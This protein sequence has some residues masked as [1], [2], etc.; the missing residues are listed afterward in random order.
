MTLQSLAQGFVDIAGKLFVLSV[1][2]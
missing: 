1:N 2:C